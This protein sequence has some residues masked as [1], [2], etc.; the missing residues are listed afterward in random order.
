MHAQKELLC[1]PFTEFGPGFF[2]GETALSLEG[3]KPLSH[4]GDKLQFLGNLAQ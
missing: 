3:L 1:S 2:N 4:P